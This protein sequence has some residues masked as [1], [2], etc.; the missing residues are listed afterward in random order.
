MI[1]VI[2]DFCNIEAIRIP[3]QTD[4]EGQKDQLFFIKNLQLLL[5]NNS[6]SERVQPLSRDNVWNTNL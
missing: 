3:R 2:E 4:R 5:T 6:Y 1:H